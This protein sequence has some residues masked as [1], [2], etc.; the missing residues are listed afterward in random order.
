MFYE[1][2]N[3]CLADHLPL[4]VFEKLVEGR[5]RFVNMRGSGYRYDTP[6]I[7]WRGKK[8]GANN[9]LDEAVVDAKVFRKIKPPGCLGSNA[10]Q[11]PGHASL[12]TDDPVR[13]DQRD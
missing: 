9:G 4:L 11:L 6:R 10:I 13:H 7:Q 5:V 3:D 1:N 8:I 2:V 12:N